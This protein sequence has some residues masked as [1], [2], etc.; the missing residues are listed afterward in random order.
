MKSL[1]LALIISFVSVNAFAINCKLEVKGEGVDLQLI[2]SGKMTSLY[3]AELG[4]FAA[5]YID[6]AGQ[7]TETIALAHE[8]GANTNSVYS[9]N[10]AWKMAVSLNASGSD[11]ATVLC[12]NHFALK[13]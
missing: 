11:S 1:F 8:D 10:S 4:G 13:R 5:S 2:Q 3:S 9:R 12:Y 6:D 7:S